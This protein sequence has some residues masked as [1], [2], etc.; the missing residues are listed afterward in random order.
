MRFLAE[1]ARL[2]GIAVGLA[3][4]C[5]VSVFCFGMAFGIVLGVVDV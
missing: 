5:A 4:V 2:A 3:F 1:F